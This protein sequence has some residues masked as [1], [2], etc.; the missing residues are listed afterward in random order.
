MSAGDAGLL[1]AATVDV[2]LKAWR[3]MVGSVLE[4]S[5]GALH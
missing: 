3:V 5:V 2:I 1:T 4:T